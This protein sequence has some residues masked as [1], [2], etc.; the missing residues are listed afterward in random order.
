MRSKTIILVCAHKQDACL[1]Q[2][3][4]LPIQ[5]G[6]ALSQVDLK[7][8]GDDTGD[9]ISTKNRNYCELTAHYWAWK[10]LG[11]ADYVGLN[12][13]RRYFDL[14]SNSPANIKTVKTTV[15]FEQEHPV[16]DIETL[17]QHCDIILPKPKIYPYNLYTDY[18]RCHIQQD[19]DTL[20]QVVL[21]K[22]PSYVDTFDKVFFHNN[23]LS[24]FNMF[25]LP[26][27]KFNAYSAWL[28]DILFEMERRI[29]ISNDPVQARVFGYLSERLLTVYAWENKYKICYK[30][31]LMIDDKRHK[32]WAKYLFHRAVN[33]TLYY[34][35]Y[36]FRV[37]TPQVTAE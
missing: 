16:P 30:P 36:L 32:G 20:R 9:N 23:R 25:I 1:A 17:F 33:N 10:N 19:L 6:K 28:F 12:H 29:R 26:R 21:E 11:E 13:Y 24:H 4:Y 2:P 7:F 5:V 31:V 18:S 15:F 27:T 35:T 8:C 22:Y 3:P 14:S 37:H 34:V